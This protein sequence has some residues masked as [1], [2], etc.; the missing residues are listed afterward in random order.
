MKTP[1]HSAT[2]TSPRLMGSRTAKYAS[3]KI[4]LLGNAGVG[5]TALGWC[6]AGGK[7]T[8]HPTNHPLQFFMLRDLSKALRDG[9]QRDA[10]IWDMASHPDYRLIHPL[11]TGDANLALI[12]FD[13]TVRPDPLAPVAY[14]LEHQ[15]AS[16]RRRCPVILVGARTEVG[17][18][19]L[20]KKELRDFSRANGVLGGY[21]STSAAT[22]EGIREL[23]NRIKSLLNSVGV[24]PTA[25]SA[26][27]NAIKNALLE[28]KQQRH[29]SS[30]VFSP[31]QLLKR[32]QKTGLRGV[33]IEE[34]LETVPQLANWGHL[35]LLGAAQAPARILIAPELFDGLAASLVREARQHP[36]GLGVLEEELVLANDF[37]FSDL[38]GLSRSNQKLMLRSVVLAFLER[39]LTLRCLREVVEQK[40]LLFFPDLVSIKRPKLSDGLQVQ[41]GASY[42][43]RGDIEHLFS[44]LVVSLGYT[45]MFKKTEHW[46]DLARYEMH[47]GPICG[48]R[49]EDVREGELDLVLFFDVKSDH[50]S[51]SVFQALVE[52]FLVRRNLLYLRYDPIICAD[53][54]HQLDRK[55][56]RDRLQDHKDWAHCTNCG[57]SLS[58][59]QATESS[60]LTR[61]EMRKLEEQEWVVEGRSRF[62]R[63]AFE[64]KE[65]AGAQRLLRPECFISYAWGDREHERWVEHTLAIDLQTA[66]VAVVLDR[67][68]NAR[69]GMS[70]PRFVE[71]IEKCDRVIVVG[72]PLYRRKYENKDTSTGYVVAAE[73]DM[74][75]G[76]MLGTEDEK[77]SVFPALLSGEER[78]SLPPLLRHRVYADFRN[79]RAYFITAFD[80]ILDLYGIAHNDPAV[81]DLRAS[82]LV[83]TVE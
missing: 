12:V 73:V 31:E 19:A 77:K 10:V 76:R 60:H 6:L 55:T 70:V 80:L 1:R 2:K 15:E 36:Q 26:H 53:C 4:V 13:P 43:V 30:P 41:E 57:A 40:S 7:F 22:G 23:K 16:R 25:V 27:F 42:T 11:A 14:W 39:N 37:Q 65:Y 54:K 34:L 68:E 20:T 33:T 75:S 32:L 58:L 38:R 59:G 24:N 71:R 18:P 46:H 44:T 69:I 66:G 83:P 67:W 29:R 8:S 28:L 79:R 78:R 72:T 5:K 21:V 45:S 56:V 64:L 48:L 47:D 82:L 61:P 49:I 74:I 3:A 17:A 35:R 81:V 9:T 51:R 50:P 52:K 63:A 62:A